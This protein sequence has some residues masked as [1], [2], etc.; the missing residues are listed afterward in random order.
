M[1][2]T[3]R[4][5]MKVWI[6]LL[7]MVMNN[8]TSPPSREMSYPLILVRFCKRVTGTCGHVSKSNNQKKDL[9]RTMGCVAHMAS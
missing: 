9:S 6:Y 5:L 1:A 4:G 7:V 2:R 8:P 3:T